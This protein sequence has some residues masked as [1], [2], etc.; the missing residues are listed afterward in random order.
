[1]H[2]TPKAVSGRWTSESVDLDG[3][4]FWLSLLFGSYAA[5]HTHLFPNLHHG[6]QQL[7]VPR[8]LPLTILFIGLRCRR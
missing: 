5:V 8:F 7:L 1:M 6:I 3:R 4:S 2:V